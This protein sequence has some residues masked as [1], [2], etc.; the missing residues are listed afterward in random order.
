MYES[1]IE[2]NKIV[3]SPLWDSQYILNMLCEVKCIMEL[4]T[5]EELSFDKYVDA[6][7]SI[8]MFDILKKYCT[9]INE[10]DIEAI[11]VTLNRFVEDLISIKNAYKVPRPYQIAPTFGVTLPKKNMVSVSGVHF[12]YPSI[13]AAGSRCIA[14]LV[15]RKYQDCLGD[16]GRYEIFNHA[17]RVAISRIH[18]GVHSVQDIREGIRL[19]DTL[20][21][22][23][24]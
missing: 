24:S 23:V 5:D 22:G 16:Y 1:G 2:L 6:D 7:F 19:A 9:N 4:A 10:S 21:W 20:C 8:G 14:Q 18:L 3:K 11:E 17:N 12:S 13:H 15:S